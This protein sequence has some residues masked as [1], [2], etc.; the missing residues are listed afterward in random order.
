[1][2]SGAKSKVSM[3]PMNHNFQSLNPL[4]D[5]RQSTE[6]IASLGRASA[7]DVVTS[8]NSIL[9]HYGHQAFQSQPQM[10]KT[11]DVAIHD[12]SGMKSAELSRQSHDNI[13]YP[14]SI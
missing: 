5:L 1:M 10:K 12:M 6:S 7:R 14:T 8:T 13:T 9:N 3:A 4:G 2:S 11:T